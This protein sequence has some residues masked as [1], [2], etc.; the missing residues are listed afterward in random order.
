MRKELRSS[1]KENIFRNTTK[2]QSPTSVCGFFRTIFR[3]Y[4]E[5]QN[6]SLWVMVLDEKTSIEGL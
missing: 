1:E 3:Y 5:T 2:A 4:L 6:A